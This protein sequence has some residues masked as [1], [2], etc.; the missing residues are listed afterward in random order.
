MREPLDVVLTRRAERQIESIDTWW[1]AN[2]PAA[3]LL[4]EREL[5]STLELVAVS[6]RIGT[7]TRSSRLPGVRRVLMRRTRYHVY[8]R[9]ERGVLVVIAVWYAKRLAPRL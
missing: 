3:P 8:Y 9:A 6:P 4:F 5:K 7:P 2:R 1:E